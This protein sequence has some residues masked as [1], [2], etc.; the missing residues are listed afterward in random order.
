IFLVMIGILLALQVNN[1]NEEW[2][3]KKLSDEYL[4]RIAEDLDRLVE[5]SGDQKQKMRE[6]LSSITKTQQLLERRTALSDYEK[7]IV[8]FAIV[9]FPRTT[10]QLPTMLTYEE[11]KESG[12]LN[13]IRNIPLRNELAE[14]YSYLLQ[15]E[16]TFG[17]LSEDTETQFTIYN[18]Y[19]RAHTDPETLEITYSYDFDAISEDEELINTFSRMSVHWRGFVFFMERVNGLGIDLKEEMS[20]QAFN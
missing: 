2:K 18:K 11:M 19:L 13:L 10:N 9:W 20:I 4:S 17:R 12:N 3:E 1:W 16:S 5:I 8:D 7:E 6:I 14:L 15:V